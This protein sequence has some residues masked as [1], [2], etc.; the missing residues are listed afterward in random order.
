M[1]DYSDD[2]DNSCSGREG[3]TK[4]VGM[5]VRMMMAEAVA[6]VVDGNG[7]ARKRRGR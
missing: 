4:S 7:S 6:V 2:N 5:E 1:L 3:W